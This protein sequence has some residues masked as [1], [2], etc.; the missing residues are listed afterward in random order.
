[1]SLS[2]YAVDMLALARTAHRSLNFFLWLFL[3]F[4]QIFFR[5]CDKKRYEQWIVG[6]GIAR[7]T[8]CCLMWRILGNLW[9]VWRS[10]ENILD[11]DSGSKKMT[12]AFRLFIHSFIH[13]S[14]KYI[15]TYQATATLALVLHLVC[16]AVVVF[17]FP[18]WCASVLLPLQTSSIPSFWCSFGDYYFM[19]NLLWLV[20]IVL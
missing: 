7:G 9:V 6:L 1:M 2:F 19:L 5:C 12:K 8:L 3:L 15:K 16:H 11:Y 4:M 20:L 10:M 14:T 17:Q 13:N 18:D